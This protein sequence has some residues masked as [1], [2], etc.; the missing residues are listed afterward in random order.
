MNI[1]CHILKASGGLKPYIKD[2]KKVCK[3][4]EGK[5]LAKIPISNVDVVIVDNPYEAIPEIGIGGYARTHNFITIAID[6]EFPNLQES[7]QLELLD[8]FAHELHHT[9]R[10]QTVG[11][12]ETLF[13]AMITEGLADHFATEITERKDL[14]LWDK[15]FNL[16]QIAEWLR[17]ADKE[18]DSKTY[19]HSDWFFGSK[20]RGMPK[21][22]GY[23][24]GF[25][26]VD[27][28]FK[29]HASVKASTLY[30]TKAEEFKK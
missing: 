8:T 23:S 9:A 12:G 20:E 25:Y 2:I 14:H 28:Y 16:K 30:K 13:E 15:A 7:L 22:I 26:L 4:A 17:K 18:F 10:L 19:S 21:W 1:N 29:K 24:L 3:E 27:N 11:Y 6:P 5:I